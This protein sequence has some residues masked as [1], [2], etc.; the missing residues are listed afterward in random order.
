MTY[1]E[2]KNLTAGLLTSDYRLPKD[3]SEVK[4]MLE[5]AFF[6][7]A[8]KIQVLRLLTTNKDNSILRTA[9]GD[10]LIRFPELPTKDDDVLDIDHE[11]CFA[12]S[13]YLASFVAKED[14]RV[15]YHE[16]KAEEVLDYYQK[17]VGTIMQQMRE[18]LSV[19]GDSY[20]CL[21]PIG[22]S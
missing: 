9:E 4:A 10:Y 22:L 18:Q 2:I 16:L 15:R 7:I 12:A 1:G 19:P 17:K 20:D 5:M 14:S 6:I 21:L 8:S 11:L 13:R 3:D